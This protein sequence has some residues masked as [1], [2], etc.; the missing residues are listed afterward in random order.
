MSGIGTLP[1]C[2]NTSTM[3]ALE[4]KSGRKCSLRAFP[5]MTH[6]RHPIPA[7]MRCSPEFRDAAEPLC[8]KPGHRPHHYYPGL[9]HDQLLRINHI[10]VCHA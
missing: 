4:G 3:S 9:G 1:T 7:P 2:Q 6:S 10:E 5:L 8:A